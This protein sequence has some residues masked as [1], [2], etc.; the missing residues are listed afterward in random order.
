MRLQWVWRHLR[1]LLLLLCLRGQE[2]HLFWS[3]G[4]RGFS[5]LCRAHRSL[6]CRLSLLPMESLSFATTDG[7][8]IIFSH[9]YIE[10]GFI[11]LLEVRG[12]CGP[13]DEIS[14]TRS[15]LGC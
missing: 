10:G 11:C 15:R 14:D 9:P 2:R 13:G 4:M 3:I 12:C 5:R 6:R 1:L 7:P 8:W